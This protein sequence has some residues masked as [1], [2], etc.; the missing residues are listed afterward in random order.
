MFDAVSAPARATLVAE[1]LRRADA[2]IAEAIRLIGSGNGIAAATGL[3]VERILEIDGRLTGADAR[4]LS[5]ASDALRSMPSLAAAFERGTVSWS[6]VRSI[7]CA[8]RGVPAA[9]R[10]QI[11]ALIAERAVT[12]AEAEPY[13]LIEL[14]D[15]AVMRLRAGRL[16][17][18]QDRQVAAEFLA[19]Q[20]RFDGGASIYGE[21]GADAA[22]TVLEALDAHADAPRRSDAHPDAQPDAGH[23]PSRARQ[24]AEAFVRLCEA[25]LSGR[26]GTRPRPRV[27][28]TVDVCQFQ[29]GRDGAMRVLWALTGRAPRLSRVAAEETMCDATIVPVVF[30]RG[31]VVDVGDETTRFSPKVRRAIIARDQGC[32]APG[33]RMPAKWSDVHHIVPG[34]GSTADDGILLCRADH[35]RAHRQRWKITLHTDGS[36][37]Y[38]IRGRTYLSLPP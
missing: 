21:F 12:L 34:V 14:V 5:A 2:A 26:G 32:R 18:R 3:P 15:D 10:D 13:R 20:G 23:A 35:R 19:V 7:V 17:S 11:D 6:Q 29:D 33:C 16:Q 8:V 37:A 9:V 28:A 36:I 31:R 27:L 24:R 38:R 1:A 25:G 30:D 22:A 4:M